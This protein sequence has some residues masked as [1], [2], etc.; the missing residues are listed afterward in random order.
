MKIQKKEASKVFQP[1]TLEITIESED[2]LTM[3]KQFCCCNEGVAET[4]VTQN[5]I[6]WVYEEVLRM[7]LKEIYKEV[8]VLA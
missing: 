2:E 7:F 8:K 1:I 6:G 5:Y 4:S 3:L